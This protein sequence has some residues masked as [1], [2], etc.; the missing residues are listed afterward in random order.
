M[1]PGERGLRRRSCEQRDRYHK[2]LIV[3]VE[4]LAKCGS[5]PNAKDGRRPVL[6]GHVK[7]YFDLNI[8]VLV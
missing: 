2:A 1:G 5:K 4:N 3:A 7:A 8:L 6:L